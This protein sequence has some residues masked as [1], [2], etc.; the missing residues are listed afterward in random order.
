MGNEGWFVEEEGRVVLNLF[1]YFMRNGWGE[2]ELVR[3]RGEGVVMW[4]EGG[5]FDGVDRL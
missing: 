1:G 5:I 2:V 3:D 4:I